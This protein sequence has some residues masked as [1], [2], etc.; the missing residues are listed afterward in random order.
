MRINT[1]L[2]QALIILLLGACLK[3]NISPNAVADYVFT[4]GRIYTV[5]PVDLAA[6]RL[7]H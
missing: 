1:L 5:N 3:S 4:N 6:Y 2:I 7:L